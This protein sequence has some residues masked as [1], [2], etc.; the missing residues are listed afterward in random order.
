MKRI[1][2]KFHSELALSIFHTFVV[3]GVVAVGGLLL[4]LVLGRLHGASGVGVFVLAQSVNLGAAIIAR[5]GMDNALMKYV[6]QQRNS[7]YVI[8]YLTWAVRRAIAFSIVAGL[9]MFVMRYIL[10]DWFNT[11]ALA[12]VLPGFAVGIPAFTL[13]FV[14]SGFLKGVRKPVTA[15]LLENGSISLLASGVVY[16]FYVFYPSDIGNIG[17]AIAISA[18]LVLGQGVWQF[19]QWFLDSKLF[20]EEKP[21]SHEEFSRSSQDFFFLSL[22]QFMQSVVSVL[23]AGVLLDSADLGVFKSA[24]RL[25]FLTTFVLLV[26]NA[27]LPPRFASL[28]RESA[29]LD[30]IALVRNG[31]LLGLALASPWLVICLIFPQALLAMFGEEF[32]QGGNVLRI[33]ALAQIVNVATGSVGFLLNMTGHEKLMRNVAFI[34]SALSLI[35]LCALIPLL[36]ILGAALGVSLALVMQN[37]M[38]LIYAWRKLGVWVLPCPNFLFWMPSDG[39]LVSG[40]KNKPEV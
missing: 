33:I 22:A 9:S 19:R 31:A 38:A 25:A 30:L 10:S 12:K 1:I 6:G 18:W 26:I 11:P 29:F 16:L 39:E 4:M 28:Y 36:G 15:C 35:A 23:I 21:V 24:E 14:L 3:R 32:T 40:Y 5:Y 37:C 17:W 2:D 7:R 20:A 34:S 13:A 8:M 27:I